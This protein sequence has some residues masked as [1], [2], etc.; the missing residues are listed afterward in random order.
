M[1]LGNASCANI[2][3]P[4]QAGSFIDQELSD[5][6]IQ[7]R[8]GRHLHF[9]VY[10]AATRAQRAQ[11]LSFVMNLPSDHGML[12][13][14]PGSQ[15]ITMWMKNTF[16]SLDL[17]FTDAQG[18]ITRIVKDA[19]PHSTEQIASDGDAYAVLELN[20]GTA[21]RLNINIGDTVRHGLLN[22]NSI[23]SRAGQ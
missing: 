16:I 7:T 9:F 6:E 5:L 22:S 21:Q 18:A 11:G 4:A 2:G 19:V 14:F 23:D 15:R 20:A 8:D 12:F 10:L 17:F 1:A 13:V 3:K